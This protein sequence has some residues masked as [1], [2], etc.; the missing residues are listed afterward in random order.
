MTKRQGA[1]G[2]TGLT[3]RDASAEINR[4]F[5]TVHRPITSCVIGFA[6]TKFAL[7]LMNHLQAT[8]NNQAT[9]RGFNVMLSLKTL[10]ESP[11]VKPTHE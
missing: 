3:A 10:L 9:Y 7:L 8:F 11:T 2:L 1:L 4:Q 5:V 6:S